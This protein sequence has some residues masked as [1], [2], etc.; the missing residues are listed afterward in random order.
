MLHCIWAQKG[1]M[2]LCTQNRVWAFHA[3]EGVITIPGVGSSAE[4]P[5]L[6]M[7]P[8]LSYKRCV[9]QVNQERPMRVMID[10]YTPSEPTNQCTYSLIIAH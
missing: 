8:L 6:R 1:G 2:Q 9:P 7:Q 4:P 5:V 10:G 3:D